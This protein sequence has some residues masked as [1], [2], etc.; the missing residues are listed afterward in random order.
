MHVD[1][2]GILVKGV[3]LTASDTAACDCF[4][5]VTFIFLVFSYFLGDNRAPL[6]D[7]ASRD[8]LTGLI[9]S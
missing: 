3:A 5:D 7:I 2:P 4:P 8:I 9:T 1:L 6:L